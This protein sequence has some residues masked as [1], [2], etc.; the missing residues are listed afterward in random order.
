MSY[1][2]FNNWPYL[3]TIFPT[4][5]DHTDPIN[6]VYFGGLHDE[7]KTVE[8]YLGLHPQGAYG[9]VVKRLDGMQLDI[10]AAMTPNTPT[11]EAVRA[12]NNTLSGA[13]NFNKQQANGIVIDNQASDPVS[14]IGGQVYYNTITKGFKFYQNN[15]FYSVSLQTL[16]AMRLNNNILKGSVNFNKNS[17]PGLVLENL[18]VKP[19]TP[20]TGQVY[21][22]TAKGCFM[23][24]G[25][26]W[27]Q[28]ISCEDSKVFDWSNVILPTTTPA[29]IIELALTNQSMKVIRFAAT[30]TTIAEFN[31]VPIR[32]RKSAYLNCSLFFVNSAVD[33]TF[34]MNIDVRCYDDG[35][36]LS[37]GGELV[38]IVQGL[39]PW[40]EPNVGKRITFQV[41]LNDSLY[42]ENITFRLKREAGA[43]DDYA[44]T[45]NLLYMTVE[46]GIDAE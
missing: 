3:A 6:N 44:S 26:G 24:K 40:N 31:Y 45:F 21:F 41:V 39:E 5:I 8:D 25:A 14:P 7:V 43:G 27:W 23:G 1:Q 13:I 17:A 29:A 4:M 37:T 36:N 11:L 16:E 42:F 19:T 9:T 46:P 22:D 20:A 38:A 10:Q 2:F 34:N 15:Y 33:G 32:I 28:Y 35:D 30:G 12:V 18:A